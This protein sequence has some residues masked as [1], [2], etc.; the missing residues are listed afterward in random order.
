MS[1]FDLSLVR[2]ELISRLQNGVR[3]YADKTR[4]FAERQPVLFV[5][6]DH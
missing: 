3:P 2:W 6:R 5:S 1:V 4:E